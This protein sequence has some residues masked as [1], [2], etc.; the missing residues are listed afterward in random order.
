MVTAPTEWVQSE[1]W[2]GKV[3]VPPGSAHNPM[4]TSL[5]RDPSLSSL[6]TFARTALLLSLSTPLVAAQMVGG[7]WSKTHLGG[8]AAGM[9]F[10]SAVAAAGDVNG[11]GF[12]DVII[13]AYSA[14]PGGLSFAGSAFVHSGA[15]GSLLH[16]FDG[17]AELD[18]FG[19]A[20]GGA[21][22]VNGDGFDDLLVGAPGVDVGL[23]SAA[24][25]AYVYSGLDG[26]LLYQFDGVEYHDRLGSAVCG[27][28]DVNLDGRGDFLIAAPLANPS[29]LES[30]GSVFLHSGFDG[31]LLQQFDGT[32][33]NEELGA[34]LAAAGDVDN[35]GRNDFIIATP[36]ANAGGYFLAGR[37]RVH[38]GSDFSVLLTLEGTAEAQ[39]LAW[40]AANAGDVDMDGHDDVILGAP[41]ATPAS[42]LRAGM[43]QVYSGFDG[44]LLMQINGRQRDDNFGMSVAGGP[45]FNQDGFDDLIIGA[46]RV[47]GSA[48]PDT[49][50][51]NIISGADESV[52]RLYEG[53]F[54]SNLGYSAATLGD[55]DGNGLDDFAMGAWKAHDS[56][57]QVSGYVDLIAYTECLSASGTSIASSLGGSVDFWIDFPPA[58]AN[59]NY[60][61]LGSNTGT[62]PI[63]SGNV[64]IPLTVD[65]FFNML[66]GPAPPP[67]ISGLTGVL[68]ANGDATATL[69]LLPDE[70]AIYVGYT[71]YFAAVS[72]EPVARA[73]EASVFVT[74]TIDP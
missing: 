36:E 22:D 13:G 8:P 59:Q 1:P 17:A 20:V 7:T 21:G 64:Q 28:G 16:Q 2:R 56:G 23:E 62:G 12:A 69:T 35:D 65:W 39:R 52:L 32:E 5:F 34:T 24:G 55:I 41:Y 49:G 15:D 29:D 27:V 6:S 3:N 51:V 37:A 26:S 58:E 50:Q 48:G 67:Q 43:A 40:S 61:L 66:T 9:R 30:A 33:V 46:S 63:S 73:R 60:F 14:A 25:R 70:A 71:F 53:T 74:V 38:S 72:F 11:D 31:S 68:D 42:V 54:N 44:S 19:S 45:D 10:G 57:N 18:Y 47:N 4:N